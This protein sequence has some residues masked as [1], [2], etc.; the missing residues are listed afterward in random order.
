MKLVV[1]LSCAFL[2]LTLSASAARKDSSETTNK[3]SLVRKVTIEP[4]IGLNPYPTSDLVFSNLVQWNVK[5]HLSLVSHTSYA[6][7]NVFLRVNNY[8]NTDYNYSLS[9]KFGVGTSLYSKRSSHTFSFIAGIKYDSFKETLK[10]PEFE[11]VSA[12]ESFISPDAGLMYSLKVGRNKYF[13]SFR[14]YIPLY[15]YPLKSSDV[16]SMDSNMANLSL[17]FGFGIRLK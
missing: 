2:L 14:T 8:V 12:A 11:Q 16:Y 9:Q 17:E 13:F 15:P 4:A 5:K 3:T 6:Y 10:N 1:F 7:N